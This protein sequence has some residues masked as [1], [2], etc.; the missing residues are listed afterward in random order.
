MGNFTNGTIGSSQWYRWLTN[1][2]NCTICRANVTID[3][4]IGTN[5]NTNGT[6]GK[7][8]NDIGIPLVPL[9]NPERTHYNTSFVYCRE[10]A[11]GT[12]SLTGNWVRSDD[13]KQ[14]SNYITI[15]YLNLSRIIRKPA[16]CI[17][18]NKDADQLRN[19]CAADQRLCFC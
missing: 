14:T 13:S 1:C 4:T 16:F 12:V 9:G 3:I 17:C 11:P 2:T 7:T 19:N 15:I 8:L 6:I 18:E 5:G 10:L